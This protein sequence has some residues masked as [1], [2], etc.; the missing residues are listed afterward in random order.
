M[1]TIRSGGA[2]GS[3]TI[4]WPTARPRSNGPGMVEPIPSTQTRAK[5]PP[6]EQPVATTVSCTWSPVASAALPGAMST[7]CQSSHWVA[8]PVATLVVLCQGTPVWPA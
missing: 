2:P 4:Q 6:S 5:W 7:S 1:A 3:R 8:L